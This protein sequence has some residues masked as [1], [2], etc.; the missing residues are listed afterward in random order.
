MF[1]D[2]AATTSED[3]CNRQDDASQLGQV[4]VE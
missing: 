4:Y 3:A 2:R 1:S